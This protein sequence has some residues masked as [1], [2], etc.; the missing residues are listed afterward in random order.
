MNY[1]F[2]ASSG[3]TRYHLFKKLVTIFLNIYKNQFKWRQKMQEIKNK[4]AVLKRRLLVKEVV[5][6]AEKKINI[7]KK[8]TS[9]TPMQPTKTAYQ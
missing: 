9:S 1:P 2:S 8:I 4:I 3:N 6:Y 5:L 7:V